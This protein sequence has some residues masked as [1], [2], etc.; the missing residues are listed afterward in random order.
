MINKWCIS[1]LDPYCIWCNKS[2]SVI[3]I[4]SSKLQQQGKDTR[5]AK[6]RALLET[7]CAISLLWCEDR[8][9]EAYIIFGVKW[10][11]NNERTCHAWYLFHPLSTTTPSTIID[12][13]TNTTDI[14]PPSHRHKQITKISD[15]LRELTWRTWLFTEW[16]SRRSR[17][18]FEIKWR[19][20]IGFSRRDIC[21]TSLIVT[22]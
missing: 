21:R 8:H 3:D 9:I 2:K 19:M 10:V 4:L 5:C 22:I 11:F 17:R 12:E 6:F 13:L 1:I 15:L 7:A 14:I 18:R 16:L 20:E